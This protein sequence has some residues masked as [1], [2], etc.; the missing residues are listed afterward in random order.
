MSTAGEYFPES[1]VPSEHDAFL[2][3]LGHKELIELGEIFPD[4]DT[5]WR[6]AIRQER[7]TRE[8]EIE[9]IRTYVPP[10]ESPPYDP[11]VGPEGYID[12]I[13]QFNMKATVSYAYPVMKDEKLQIRQFADQ[14]V[15]RNR[16]ALW[17]STW[18]TARLSNDELS[19]FL[20]LNL[21]GIALP[22][23][24]LGLTAF[25]SQ[26]CR[27]V[28]LHLPTVRI[29]DA[30]IRYQVRDQDITREQIEAAKQ[31]VLDLPHTTPFPDFFQMTSGQQAAIVAALGAEWVELCKI[32]AQHDPRALGVQALRLQGPLSYHSVA[33]L[34]QAIEQNPSIEPGK[35]CRLFLRQPR[36]FEAGLEAVRKDIERKEQLRLQYET[37]RT[38]LARQQSV[39]PQSQEGEGTGT[40]SENVSAEMYP[41]STPDITDEPLTGP[42]TVIKSYRSDAGRLS[43]AVEFITNKGAQ[44]FS[45]YAEHQFENLVELCTVLPAGATYSLSEARS[46]L[47]EVW[48]PR[49]IDA[50]CRHIAEAMPPGVFTMTEAAISIGNIVLVG[51]KTTAEDVLSER[52]RLHESKKA[53][54]DKGKISILSRDHARIKVNNARTGEQ[55]YYMP[56]DRGHALLAARVIFALRSGKGEEFV[57]GGNVA[58]FVWKQM[59]TVERELF[60][61]RRNEVIGG[62]SVIKKPVLDVMRKLTRLIGITRE[63]SGE[64]FK[65]E[66]VAT[67]TLHEDSPDPSELQG[68]RSVFPPGTDRERIKQAAVGP[69]P[70]SALNTARLLLE[71]QVDSTE[72]L[73]QGQALAILDLIT[74]ADVKRAI[75]HQI[76][77][78]KLKRT[79]AN[80]LETLRG[81]VEGALDESFESAWR[82]RMIAGNHATGDYGKVRLIG[83]EL[84]IITNPARYITKKWHIGQ[85][86]T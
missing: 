81:Q 34:R 32:T 84:P 22:S 25:E 13:R 20:Y 21:R 42:V 76:K 28:R 27:T 44:R 79:S 35:I 39:E 45:W 24:A 3:S 71:H 18:S 68:F 60:T 74:D 65:L 26:K 49:D 63:T 85:S 29:N 48:D 51:R 43:E 16:P 41:Q 17:E 57:D 80:V 19:E 46:K 6:L 66:G 69:I 10:A 55:S 54:I 1:P 58:V 9:G 83:G 82:N 52:K 59:P 7:A 53:E 70:D 33:T 2:G 4:K 56:L 5:G 50:N 14:S 36:E 31:A 75:R 30:N 67:I 15:A 38:Q 40:M 77:A 72:P 64:R 12:Q 11:E 86:P 78:M 8:R 62:S 73:S 61:T 23:R 47:A 37:Q